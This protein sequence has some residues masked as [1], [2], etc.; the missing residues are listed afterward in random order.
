MFR[1]SIFTIA[2]IVGGISSALAAP[3]IITGNNTKITIER[4]DK[5]STSTIFVNSYQFKFNEGRPTYTLN[6]TGIAN[7]QVFKLT[8]SGNTSTK[9][10]TSHL[11]LQGD[12]FAEIM[13]LFGKP[14]LNST[15]YIIKSNLKINGRLFKFNRIYANIWGGTVKGGFS[16]NYNGK[17]PYYTFALTG[18]KL[19]AGEVLKTLHLNDN[20]TRGKLNLKYNVTS[21]GHHRPEF[22]AH[23]TGNATLAM[24]N[25]TY[26]SGNLAR[27]TKNLIQLFSAGL[28][29]QATTINCLIMQL[30][31]DDGI[32]S[33][34]TFVFDTPGATVLG[35]GTLNY[36]NNTINFIISPSA[37]SVDLNPLAIPMHIR[38]PIGS[39]SV[40]PAPAELAKSLTESLFGVVTGKKILATVQR[41]FG[42][43][44]GNGKG[45][46]NCIE[47]LQ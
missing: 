20:I 28:S 13:A 14:F 38:G 39:P 23:Q 36:R 33:A 22:F 2:I 12:N 15:N 1:R 8:G 31:L 43:D 40:I 27:Y 42:S 17:T 41:I 4:K 37:K 25:A 32:G 46:Q 45:L 34:N 3:I 5:S 29:P 11:E 21:Y 30:Y 6:M 35:K 19:N 18:K 26:H 10:L 47:A 24:T 44:L 9:N 16:L 7:N